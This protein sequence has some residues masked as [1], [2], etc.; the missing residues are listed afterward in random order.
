MFSQ[1][2]KNIDQFHVDP[3]MS[4]ADLGSG[5]GFYT[6]ALA[7]KVGSAGRVYSID[8]QK[9][10]LSKIQNEAR[11][12]GVHNIKLIWG[13]L[14]AKKG[15]NLLDSFVDRVVVANL[16]FQ[17]EDKDEVIEEAYRI[18]KPKGKLLFVDWR[19]SFGGLGP[20]PKDIVKPDVAR[21]LFEENGFEF[22]KEI[23]A[24]DHHYGFVFKK[25]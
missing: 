21:V 25:K 18:L 10:L 7:K 14:N 5:S 13:D 24:G 22:E 9:E 2:D 15:S 4:V 3:G 23:M 8:V 20:Q 6:I 16:L 11:N 12:Q 19:D 17:V 1:P